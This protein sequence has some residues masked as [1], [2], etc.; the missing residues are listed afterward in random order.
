M[1][2]L[3]FLDKDTKKFTGTFIECTNKQSNEIKKINANYLFL[4]V[5]DSKWSEIK[6]DLRFAEF[7]N[8]NIS[9]RLDNKLSVLKKELLDKIE[10][11]CDELL[12]NFMP[13]SIYK[14]EEYKYIVEI[15]EKNTNH[16][17]LP[18]YLK[19]EAKILDKT[20][21]EYKSYVL[22]LKQQSYDMILKCRAFRY[23]A[24]EELTKVSDISKFETTKKNIL[25]KF[26]KEFDSWH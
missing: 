5:S 3:L 19:K 26:E 21:S 18:A 12:Y 16:E 7:K 14:F 24:K 1:G 4:Y 20:P 13:L 8:N 25:S 22:L 6:D 23:W 15:F 9:I 2:A 17:Q 11:K 10:K